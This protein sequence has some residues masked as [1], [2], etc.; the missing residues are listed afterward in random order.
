MAD[1]TNGVALHRFRDCAA[2]ATTGR[3]GTVYLDAKGARQ[4]ARAAAALAR[5]L[6]RRD[7][8]ESTFQPQDV[9]APRP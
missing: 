4:L 9:K 5:D 8:Q 3:A 7:F 6:E 1:D 2:I